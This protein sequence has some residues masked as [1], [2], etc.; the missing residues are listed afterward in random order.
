MFLLHVFTPKVPT[1]QLRD[2]AHPAEHSWPKSLPPAACGR[3]TSRDLLRAFL[4]FSTKTRGD[5]VQSVS[6]SLFMNP[7]GI[8][9]LQ[10]SLSC[11]V[12]A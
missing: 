10:D 11:L 9:L 4:N 12:V 8:R 2:A 1:G 6:P 3:R 7:R 5:L